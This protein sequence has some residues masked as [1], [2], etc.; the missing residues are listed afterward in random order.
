MKHINNSINQIGVAWSSRK[1]GLFLDV[2]VLAGGTALGQILIVLVS[3]LLTRLYSPE[4]FGTLAV[5]TS[6]LSIPLVFASL[7]YEQAIPLAKNENS[8][9]NL[10]AFCLCMVFV[11]STICGL[12]VLF[13]GVRMGRWPSFGGLGLYLWILPLSLLGAGAYQALSYSSTRHRDFA[14]LS[15]SKMLQAVGMVSIQT[16]GGILKTGTKGLII[17][18]IVSQVLGVGLL[19]RRSRLRSSLINPRTWGILA[20]K[21]RKFPL[22]STWDSLLNVVGAQAPYLILAGCFKLETAGQFALAMRV[23]GMP[24]A[25]IGQAMAQGL[26]PRLA[27]S[28]P[29]SSTARFVEKCAT[30]LA[31][32]SY[33]VFAFLALHGPLL[34]AY[35]FGEHWYAAGRYAQY[36]TPCLFLALIASPLSVIALAKDKLMVGLLFGLFLASLRLVMLWVGTRY[37]SADL[38]VGLFSAAGCINYFIYLCYLLH[39][40]GSGLSQWMRTNKLFIIGGTIQLVVLM[41]ATYVFHPRVA[42]VLSAVCLTYTG[43]WSLMRIYYHSDE[44]SISRRM[45]FSGPFNPA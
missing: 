27:E 31:I 33:M 10:L 40:V 21:F 34:F 5:Y 24:S 18:Y 35:V 13:I 30:S 37:S 9:T 2:L 8:A 36:Q 11:V 19:L 7:R 39:L 1:S 43:C 44:G 16:F 45:R 41:V 25:L 38:A 15:Y 42:L 23:L 28:R 32:V 3:P 29:D 12:G 17:G 26:Y 6:A 14:A 20:T 22:F 4:A